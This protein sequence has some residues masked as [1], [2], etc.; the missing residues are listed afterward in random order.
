MS[1][2]V[3]ADVDTVEVDPRREVVLVPPSRLSEEVASVAVLAALSVP[4]RSTEDS[5]EAMPHQS[6]SPDG[7]GRT[8]GPKLFADEWDL[9]KGKSWRWTGTHVS[10]VPREEVQICV[11]RAGE[12]I[13]G[14]CSSQLQGITTIVRRY[15]CGN[16]MGCSRAAEEHKLDQVLQ[17]CRPAP[18]PGSE[19]QVGSSS[20][21]L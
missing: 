2:S 16:A 8:T 7:S 13:S 17:N 10:K 19:G 6:A 21:A 18:S 14:V 9:Q 3:V 4:C 5:M 1:P 12:E 11:L 20:V 15:Y